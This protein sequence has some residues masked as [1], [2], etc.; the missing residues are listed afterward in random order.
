MAVLMQ[1][2]DRMMAAHPNSKASA[3][4]KAPTLAATSTMYCYKLSHSTRV[5]IVF[6]VRVDE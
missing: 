3:L 2:L 6:S 5:T 1:R 4:Q